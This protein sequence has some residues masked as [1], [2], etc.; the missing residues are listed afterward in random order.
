MHR[1]GIRQR[2]PSRL[3]LKRCSACA[4]V[5]RAEDFYESQGRLSSYCNVDNA[6]RTP[7]TRWS[8]SR[9]G[10]SGSAEP[11]SWSGWPPLLDV[12]WCL[13]WLAQQAS[14]PP[15]AAGPADPQGD[16][17]HLT[18]AVLA[19]GRC[20]WCG[21]EVACLDAVGPLELEGAQLGLDAAQL[22]V[23]DRGRW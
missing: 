19:L 8:S 23:G 7:S 6:L 10:K 12:A 4:V 11:C 13:A 20:G 2:D 9:S 5:K 14:Q 1:D 18:L 16:A 15:G 17:T 22:V 21:V 3:E